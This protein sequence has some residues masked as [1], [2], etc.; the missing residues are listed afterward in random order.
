MQIVS[1]KAFRNSQMSMISL[2]NFS[3]TFKFVSELLSNLRV[4]MIL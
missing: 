4:E 2:Q 3:V 1:K